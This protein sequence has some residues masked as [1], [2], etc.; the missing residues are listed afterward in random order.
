MPRFAR[1]LAFS[2]LSFALVTGVT[3]GLVEVAH[4]RPA[5]AYAV[6]L[7]LALSFNFIVNRHVVFAAGEKSAPGRQAV[8]FV[9]A[10]VV[11]RLLEYAAFVLLVDAL[12]M[13]YAAAAVGIPLVSLVGKYVVLD[14]IV[15][16]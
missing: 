10:S 16:R 5:F 9:A 12:G 11:F 3:I 14:R 4:S 15:F 13:P 2:A 8:R 1:F 6:A 7:G